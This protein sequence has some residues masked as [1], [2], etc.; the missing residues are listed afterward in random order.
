MANN[1]EFTDS[2]ENNSERIDPLDDPIDELDL[3]PEDPTLLE[4][5][6]TLYEDEN[7]PPKSKL[8]IQDLSKLDITT[9]RVITPEVISRQATIN[10]G[11]IGHVA[12]GK[13]TVVKAISGVQTVRFTIEVKKNLTIKLGLVFMEYLGNTLYVDRLFLDQFSSITYH[14]RQGLLVY[15]F[16][17]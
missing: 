9:L 7:T 17:A 3:Y 10:I 5:D 2:I 1:L 11:T 8:A 4:A 6:S 13:S 16:L 15:N 12:H 14:R